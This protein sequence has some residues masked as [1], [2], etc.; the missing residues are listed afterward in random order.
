M[1]ETPG[2]V[3]TPVFVAYVVFVVFV[4]F[5]VVGVLNWSAVLVPEVQLDVP[6]PP[7]SVTVTSTAPVLLT[8]GLVAE[9]WVL[10]L[11][12]GAAV[13]LM[14]PNCTVA[15]VKLVPVTVTLVPAGPLVGETPVTVGCA[16]QVLVAAP[17]SGAAATSPP[18]SPVAA[19]AAKMEL[20]I[21]GECPFPPEDLHQGALTRCSGQ[22]ATHSSHQ[23]FAA[24]KNS[25]LVSRRLTTLAGCQ[26]IKKDMR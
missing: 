22:R 13:A 4:V 9:I 23:S 26:A 21:M 12:T 5:V 1:G 17:A 2:T 24:A 16:A 7:G 11:L 6:V 25:Y 3:G 14:P 18:T 19:T 20:W 10:E 15:P 8:A